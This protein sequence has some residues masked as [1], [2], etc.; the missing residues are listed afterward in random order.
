MSET[1]KAATRAAQQFSLPGTGARGMAASSASGVAG[2]AFG[3]VPSSTRRSSDGSTLRLFILGKST[4]GDP[5]TYL[6]SEP[7]E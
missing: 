1:E 2:G 6:G 4:L 7:L 5:Q 3:A